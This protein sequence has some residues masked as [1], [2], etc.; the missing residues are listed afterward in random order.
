MSVIKLSEKVVDKQHV[1]ENNNGKNK[2]VLVLLWKAKAL[3]YLGAQY[4]SAI[5][6]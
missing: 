2:F 4:S 5:L 6:N 1:W 3:H